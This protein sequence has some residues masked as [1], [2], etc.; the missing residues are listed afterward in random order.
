MNTNAATIERFYTAFAN[1]NAADMAACYHQ[2]IAFE[3]PIFGKLQDEKATAMWTMLLER[4]K[5]NLTIEYSAIKANEHS[6][7]AHWVA[8]Y[9][10]SK[11]GRKVVNK[12]DA[13][14]EFKDGLIIKHTDSFDLWKWS[15]QAF[16]V[17]GLLLG[18]T[19]F[20]QNKI[21]KQAKISLDQYCGKTS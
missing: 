20:M 5:G 3:D 14:F 2:D 15:K 10:F 18:W 9:P 17:K 13:E 21:R 4:S 16:G 12:I 19:D 6:G 1:H 11:T 7:S 8:T